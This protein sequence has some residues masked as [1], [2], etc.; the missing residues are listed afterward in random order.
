MVCLVIC[1]KEED[2]SKMKHQSGHNIFPLLVYGDFLRCSRAAIS[3][4]PGRIL[5]I[6]KLISALMVVLVT[7]KNENDRIRNV[8]AREVTALSIYF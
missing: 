1:K 7:G 2:P 5:Q 3:L 4:V 8:G 6:F